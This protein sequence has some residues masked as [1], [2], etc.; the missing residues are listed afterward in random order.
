MSPSTRIAAETFWE[1][2]AFALNSVV[3]L[4]VGLQVHVSEL[5]QS[6]QLIL[7]AYAAVTLARAGVVFGV[8]VLE[9]AYS[10][11]AWPASWGTVLTWGGI[12][13]SLS[14]V[15]AL[16]LPPALAQRDLLI[17]VTFGVVLLSIMVQGLTMKPLLQRLGVVRGRQA[18][19]TYQIRRGELHMTQAA[20]AE[21]G[22]MER[23]QVTSPTVLHELREEY[24]ARSR[25]AA[26]AV[27]ALRV[28]QDDLRA[29]ESV[30]ARRQVLLA[31]KET[32]LADFHL[33]ILSA[34]A[35]RALLASVDA[36]LAGLDTGPQL[37]DEKHDA[38]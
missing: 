33:G 23:L 17:T 18:R 29:E 4:L 8:S 5:A 2:V 36:R 22:E 14:M 9:R 28:K 38:G 1:Y 20:L 12:R 19:M 24:E 27:E 34:E 13:G 7:V 30:R 26:T 10:R 6:W 35:E 37:A 25:E 11:D 15:L 16:A 21:I 32:V 31:E 3:F